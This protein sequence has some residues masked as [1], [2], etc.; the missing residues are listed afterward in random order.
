MNKL[1]KKFIASGLFLGYMKPAPGTWGSAGACSVYLLLRWGLGEDPVTLTVAMI[2][3]AILSTFA[4]IWLGDFVEEAWGKKDPSK[5]TIDEWAGQAVT[6]FFLPCYDNWTMT[7]V[8][9]GVAFFAFRIFDIIKPP[10]ARQAERFSKGV[11]VVADDL[12]AGLYACIV[13]LLILNCLLPR[14]WS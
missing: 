3:I 1:F 2:A 13:T 8:A 14:I 10:P 5:C 6:M 4:C 11:G 7:L 12:I 9:V